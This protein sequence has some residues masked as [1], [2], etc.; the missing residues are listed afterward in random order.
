[1]ANVVAEANPFASKLELMVEPRWSGNSWA[2]FADT[3]QQQVISVA[4]LD[5]AR[6]PMLEQRPGW[7]TLGTEF[8]AVLDFGAGVTDTR[9]A[10]LNP[11]D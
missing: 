5:G 7:T 3:A 9:G 1:M 2:V 8:R 4:Y 6:G 10:F 11:G